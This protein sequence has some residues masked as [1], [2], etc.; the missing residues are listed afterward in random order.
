MNARQM[1]YQ[2]GR[3]FYNISEGIY[4][5]IGWAAGHNS[6]KFF[7]DMEN[8]H[9][10]GNIAMGAISGAAALFC[11]YFIVTSIA[12]RIYLCKESKEIKGN[13]ERYPL[14]HV[15]A[16]IID[17]SD[18]LEEL[19]EKTGENS[20]VE[21]GTFLNAH[22]EGDKAIID[23]FLDVEEGKRNGLIC[24]R[25]PITLYLEIARAYDEGYNGYHH[26]HPW[27]G[28][29]N[30]Y[31]GFQDRYKPPNWINF[32]TFNMPE[33]PEIIGFNRQYTYIPRERKNKRKLVRATHEDIMKYLSE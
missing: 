18:G 25:T 26:C 22:P 27:F 2:I 32:L 23:K 8:I 28:A 4:L 13:K 3:L 24:K 10:F 20:L 15:D 1:G 31:L 11:G 29:T 21:W 7:S 33:G 19:L 30:Y 6:A 14:E 9:D 17:D 5:P 12:D 16:V